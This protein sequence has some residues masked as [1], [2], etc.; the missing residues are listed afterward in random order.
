MILDRLAALPRVEMGRSPTP[1]ER[2]DRISAETGGATLWAKRDDLND[3]AFGGNK[4]RQLEYYF[5]AARAEG[6]DTVLI[7]GAVQ[8]N[9][10]RLTAAFAA[11]LGMACHI[12]QEE[13]VVG[14]DPTY[15]QSGN[16]LLQRL[17]GA[18][19]HSYPSGEDESG[20]D[21]NLER[22]AAGLRA[23]GHRPY[24]IH[25]APGHP[26]LGAL[27]YIH[28][29]AEVLAEAEARALTIDHA[30]VPSGSGA[31]HGGFLFGLR[32][33]GS[34]IP[35]T[36]ICV[37]RDAGA[38]GP[39]I[40]ARCREIA[41]LIDTP[42]PVS[43][44]DVMVDDRFLAPGYGRLNTATEH[45]IART[46]QTEAMLLDPVYSGKAMAGALTHAEALGP[47][48]T[49]LFLHTGGTPALFAYAGAMDAM[50]QAR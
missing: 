6:A 21:A 31:T 25:L 36:G 49:V 30:I 16:V 17:L 50:L 45:A 4:V 46:A 37:R 9:Y 2:L 10:C 28:A 22:I 11:R 42:N 35:V 14:A 18:C 40:A 24:V 1:L 13:R 43:D 26:P 41:R 27:G 15:R 34:R 19:L 23:E 8:S 5:G 3:L 12:Q 44:A 33:L 39:R 38:Q 47:G 48:Q 20:A 32:A 29:A 7:T